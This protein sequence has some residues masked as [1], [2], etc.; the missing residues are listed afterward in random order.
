MFVRRLRGLSLFFLPE[1][2]EE[3]SLELVLEPELVLSAG[4]DIERETNKKRK[5]NR[6]ERGRTRK[7]GKKN[8]M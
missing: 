4:E 6:G 2:F 8:N 1:F 7:C 5:K 3:V